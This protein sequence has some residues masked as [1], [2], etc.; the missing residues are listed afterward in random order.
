MRSSWLSGPLGGGPA[1]VHDD[2]AP[3]LPPDAHVVEGPLVEH[4][5]GTPVSG[6]GVQDG[7]RV[8]RRADSLA[9]SGITR[10]Q[11]REVAHQAL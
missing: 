10:G 11:G 7:A 8:M 3:R 1:D 9:E 5:P 2:G 4:L 6:G